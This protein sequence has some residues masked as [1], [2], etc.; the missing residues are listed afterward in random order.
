MNID[1][2]SGGIQRWLLDLATSPP[3]DRTVIVAANRDRML[4]DVLEPIRE[5]APDDITFS[6]GGPCTVLGRRVHIVTREEQLL[7]MTPRSILIHVWPD[8]ATERRIRYA[9]AATG[10][11][12]YYV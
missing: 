5:A 1:T 7:G 6:T 3:E 8:W 4:R 10:C 9:H 2:L 11:Q 12:I